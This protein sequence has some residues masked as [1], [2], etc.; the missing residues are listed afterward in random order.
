VVSLQFVLE[1]RVTAFIAARLRHTRRMS[2][3]DE[4]TEGQ[5][6]PQPPD[7]F[8]TIWKRMVEKATDA[9]DDDFVITVA[10][11][12]QQSVRKRNA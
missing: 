10:L 8:K 1:A 7:E 11:E 9:M 5:N 4:E 6:Q 3:V 12:A 2:R